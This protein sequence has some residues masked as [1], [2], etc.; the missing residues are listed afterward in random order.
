MERQIKYDIFISHASEDKKEIARPL[1]Y[2]LLQKGYNVFLDE[3]A[4]KL[5]DSISDSINK[6]L[7]QAPNGIVIISPVF[8]SK[9][10]TRAE[11]N[12][13]TNMFIGIGKKVLPIWHGVTYDDIVKN[14]PLLADI[15]SANSSEKIETLVKQIQEAVGPPTY[16]RF[17][18]TNY[19]WSFY[20][21][22][23]NLQISILKNLCSIC[24]DVDLSDYHRVLENADD[25]LRSIEI[26][27][28]ENDVR[29][30]LTITKHKIEEEI[31]DDYE[32]LWN[33]R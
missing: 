25:F 33:G 24:S 6:G 23:P 2:A 12:S 3:L 21:F 8:L 13:I 19:I 30:M 17:S 1:A 9:N 7:S 5:G 26:G 27:K 14:I 16:K 32:D 29:E 20:D 22:E 11:L 18:L 10:W 28:L 31:Q 15:K 4:I